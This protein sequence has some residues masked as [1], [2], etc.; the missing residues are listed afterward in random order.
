MEPGNEEKMFLKKLRA[1]LKAEIVPFLKHPSAKVTFHLSPLD[2]INLR[3]LGF[4]DTKSQVS[5]AILT[6][7]RRELWERFGLKAAA[8]PGQRG[9][10]IF[11]NGDLGLP[12]LYP[13]QQIDYVRPGQVYLLPGTEGEV[14]F[15]ILEQ[16]WFQS[17]TRPAAFFS[18]V[19]V[20]ILAT[21]EE[22][23]M[24]FLMVSF[25]KRSVADEQWPEG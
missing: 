24:P 10:L 5:E 13:E 4:T 25:A 19:K 9:G 11:A 8:Y 23:E 1:W 6:H 20:K 3:V 21:G 15:Q 7:A 14:K 2:V 16:V 12:P 17:K 18:G 22:A